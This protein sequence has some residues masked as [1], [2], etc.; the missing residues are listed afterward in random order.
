M[1]R[2]TEG[3]HPE[4]LH[5]GLFDLR[6]P[7]VLLERRRE[8]ARALGVFDLRCIGPALPVVVGARQLRAP[9][10]VPES[11]PEDAALRVARDEIHARACMAGEPRPPAAVRLLD[12]ESALTRA[13]QD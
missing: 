3:D 6:G 1:L 9:M 2:R 12:E 10:P 13:D 8:I 5:R 7:L 4:L 11:G